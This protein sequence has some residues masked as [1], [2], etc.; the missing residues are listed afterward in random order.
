[1]VNYNARTN[2]PTAYEGPG[3]E[4]RYQ[5]TVAEALEGAETSPVLMRPPRERQRGWAWKRYSGKVKR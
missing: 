3:W 2:D 5:D 1:M 4:N